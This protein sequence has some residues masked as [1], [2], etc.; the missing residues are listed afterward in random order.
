M[1]RCPSPSLSR[2]NR[3][4]C[5]NFEGGKAHLGYAPWWL[6]FLWHQTD[7]LLHTKDTLP[8]SSYLPHFSHLWT[9][10]TCVL[11]AKRSWRINYSQCICPEG[12]R[13]NTCQQYWH[14][15][16][17][18]GFRTVLRRMTQAPCCTMNRVSRS[19]SGMAVPISM[20]SMAP[21]RGGLHT[22]YT[23]MLREPPTQQSPRVVGVE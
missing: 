11:A 4:A 21:D 2:E 8:F 10:K 3:M 7:P 23:T 18:N 9:P 20:V 17:M 13:R 12:S 16:S 6:S 5:K 14:L 15:Q 1:A 22:S 19:V